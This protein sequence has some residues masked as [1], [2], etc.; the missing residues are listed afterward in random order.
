MEFED[1][2]FTL[3]FLSAPNDSDAELELTY[4]WDGDELK[5]SS[6]NFGHI[7]YR[8]KIF[9]DGIEYSTDKFYYMP[10]ENYKDID[11][12]IY[13]SSQNPDSIEI[14]SSH[15]VIS[16]DEESNKNQPIQL[17]PQ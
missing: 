14:K 6:R 12:T 13:D 15:I 7:A 2:R 8:V 9:H 17:M 4:N 11:L 5:T 10:E 16:Y 1:D 3:I